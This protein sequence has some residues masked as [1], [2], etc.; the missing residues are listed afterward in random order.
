MIKTE[1]YYLITGSSSGL[2]EALSRLL[3]QGG[4]NTLGL[5]KIEGEYTSHKIDLSN[6]SIEDILK[7][8]KSLNGKKIESIIHCAAIQKNPGAD[9]ESISDTFNE[10]FSVNVKSVY[11]LVKTLEKEFS[12]FTKLCI[13]SSVHAKA[14]SQN[15]TL[16]A[17]SKSAIHGLVNGLTLEKNEKMSIFELILGA[18]DSPMLLNSFEKNE[19]EDLKQDLPSKNILQPA[20]VAQFI[21]DL[22]N[23]HAKILHG[24]SIVVDN[25]VLSKLP[26]K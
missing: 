12:D 24:S 15:N 14:T 11:L 18:M 10:V 20:D 6:I 22:I 26:T 5:D 25:G 16:Y 4:Y 17:S 21:I 7:I 13:V 2:G 19:I 8:T 1:N 23:N 9:F 3:N